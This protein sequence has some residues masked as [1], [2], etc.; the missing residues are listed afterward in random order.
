[1][2]FIFLTMDGNHS[3][4]LRAAVALL[5][6]EHGVEVQLGIYT[7]TSLHSDADWQRLAQDIAGADFVFGA[8]LFGEEYV[9]P[10]QPLLETSACPV[11]IITSNPALIHCTRLGKF[12][13]AKGED[14]QEPG[15]FARWAHKLRPK[16]GTGEGTRQ[17][18]F[19]RN[20]G[21]IMQH[22]PGKARDLH[23]YITLHDYWLNCSPENLSACCAW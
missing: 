11:C 21:K 18:A 5:R 6:R 8:M 7:A 3:A 9:R 12:V 13:L 4:A 1:M 16:S 15:L 10:L 19:V 17:L 23:S 2:R 22:I 14:T 20:L